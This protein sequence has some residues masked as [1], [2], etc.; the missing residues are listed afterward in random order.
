MLGIM[1][2]EYDD[3]NPGNQNNSCIYGN[4]NYSED[5]GNDSHDEDKNASLQPGQIRSQS[6]VKS[7]TI[8]QFV[9]NLKWVIRP[10]RFNSANDGAI[11]KVTATMMI[12]FMLALIIISFCAILITS[13]TN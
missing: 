3:F 13:T 9:E 8:L 11:Y 5:D 1:T 7:L 6:P 4:D 2:I 10:G 12:T